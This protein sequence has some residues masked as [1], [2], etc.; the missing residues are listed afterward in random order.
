MSICI[1]EFSQPKVFQARF[2]RMHKLSFEL[3]SSEA[4]IPFNSQIS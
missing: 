1:L 4:H 2:F 3:V